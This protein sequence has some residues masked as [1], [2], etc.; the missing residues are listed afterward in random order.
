MQNLDADDQ[1]VAYV[2]TYD[3]TINYHSWRMLHG[4]THRYLV[5]FFLCRWLVQIY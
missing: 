5:L 3:Q 4:D 1:I 2:S